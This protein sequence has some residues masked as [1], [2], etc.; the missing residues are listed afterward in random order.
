MDRQTSTN[1]NSVINDCTYIKIIN[2]L[3][4]VSINKKKKASRMKWHRCWEMQKSNKENKNKQGPWLSS[5][6][7]TCL[8]NFDPLKPHFYI[9]KL[10]FTGVYIIFLISAQSMFG[11]EIWKISV[12]LSENFQFLE[13][14]FSIYLN[15]HVFVMTTDEWHFVQLLLFLF[16]FSK[17]T[18]IVGTH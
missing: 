9:V 5:I 1:S 13:V 12:F 8:Y 7:K 16:H 17:N 6:T 4:T 2:I 15:R 3:S 18:Y 10:G 11:E 14:K